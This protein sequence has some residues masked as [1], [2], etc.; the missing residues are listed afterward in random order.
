MAS[1]HYY[2]TPGGTERQAHQLARGLIARGHE[3]Q[4]LTMQLGAEPPNV[5]IEGVPVRRAVRG[6]ERGM[7]FGISYL[8]TSLYAL[9]S[10]GRRANILHAHQLYLDAAAA[11]TAGRV[12]GIP[13][14]AKVAC[15][16]SGG[17]LNRL[18]RSWAGR[19][20]LSM[21]LRGI[22]RVVTPSRETEAEIC[23][24]GFLAGRVV[25]IPNGV[26]VERFSPSFG[27]W[28]TEP[29][30]LFLGRLDRQKGLDTLI[31]AWADVVSRVRSATLT[32]AGQGPELSRL[33]ALAQRVGVADHVCFLGAVPDP[34][35][36]LRDAAAFVLPSR[37]EGLPNALLEAMAT[38]VPCVATAIGGTID[39][40]TDQEDALLVPP[41]DSRAL[42]EALCVVL[43]DRTIA[44]KLGANAR[45]RVVANFSLESLISRYE[46]LYG[47]MRDA[48]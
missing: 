5:V 39:V 43:T 48:A 31:T 3:V 20:L 8:C 44:R 41:D 28:P 22:N 15:G 36:R 16:G 30:V 10:L 23:A 12:L 26:D 1:S 42:A 32:I 6:I 9:L 29:N 37:F 27:R 34:E 19:L 25:C 13:V 17:D 21:V 2:P 18:R 14:L 33:A 45:R 24:A 11:T 38:G 47:E 4:V 40:A 7:L 35:R 46:R